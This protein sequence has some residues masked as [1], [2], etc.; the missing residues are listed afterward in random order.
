MTTLRTI[1][2][3]LAVLGVTSLA[4]GQ[5]KSKATNPSPPTKP[6]TQPRRPQP[7]YPP[8]ANTPPHSQAKHV[9]LAKTPPT[10]TSSQPIDQR[11]PASAP[12]ASPRYVLHPP[13]A[14]TGETGTSNGLGKDLGRVEVTT[15]S[16]HNPPPSDNHAASKPVTG[17]NHNTLVTGYSSPANAK[18]TPP[19]PA[20]ALPTGSAT[21][22]KLGAPAALDSSASKSVVRQVNT[23]RSSMSGINSR[24]LPQG[25]VL[26]HPDGALTI[27]G[28]GGRQYHVR[29]DGTVAAFEAH[30]VKTSFRPNGT[31]SAIH[32]SNMHINYAVSGARRVETVRPDNSV[33][34]STGPHQGYLQRTVVVNDRTAVQRIYVM[35]KTT[36]VRNYTTYTYRGVVLEHYVPAVYYA[37]A[38]YGWVYYPWSHPVTYRWAFYEAPWYGYYGGYFTPASVYPTPSLWLTD[39]LLAQTLSNAYQDQPATVA[40]KGDNF[41]QADTAI[42]PETKQILAAE[43]QEMVAAGNKVAGDPSP[44]SNLAGELPDVVKYERSV[45]VVAGNLDVTSEDGECG[46][47]PGDILEMDAPLS[48]DAVTADV[49]VISSKRI[50]CPASSMVRI[51]VDQL[52]EMHNNLR[53]RVDEGMQL[54]RASQGSSGIPVAPL[55]AIAPPPRPNYIADASPLSGEQVVAMIAEQQ[56]TADVTPQVI[57]DEFGG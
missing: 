17:T 50:D 24:P 52:Q 2:L 35:N 33:L 37:P 19:R 16:V 23:A 3:L 4:S 27:E 29:Q 41:A 7:N 11:P 18:I 34:V 25:K 56:Q 28:A 22:K 32:T 45:F 10:P 31:V 43:V 21:P 53:Q 55:D 14:A 6:N 49:R 42:S 8:P 5:E 13:A 51:S 54:L 40:P 20:Y 15:P 48:Q 12:N 57:Q 1:S 26:V 47:T 38:F 44:E 46:L 30:G 39:Y 9:P 36:Y